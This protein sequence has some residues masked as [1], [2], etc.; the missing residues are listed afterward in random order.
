[1]HSNVM[2]TKSILIKCCG[3]PTS[4][5]TFFP[6]NGL[7]NLAS[8]LIEKGHKTIIFDFATVDMIEKMFPY[9]YR[10]EI[11]NIN[12]RFT[13]YKNKNLNIDKS[14][15][16]DAHKL[17]SEI[18]HYQENKI[19]SITQDIIKYIKLNNIDFVGIKLITG[20]G[21]KSSLIIAEELKKNIPSLPIF[22]G[23]PHVDWFMEKIYDV[24]D[25][26]D[27]LA[28]GEGEEIITML[29]DYV[30]GKKKLEEVPNII[31]RENGRIIVNPIKRIVDLNSIP[32]PVYDE[33]VYP[34]MKDNQKL[35]MVMI[36]ESRGC[37]NS[38]N[39]CIHPQKSGRKW[40]TTS[41]ERIVNI[42]EHIIEQ[43]GS[44]I[45]RFAGSNPPPYIRREIAEEI[46]KRKLKIE[47]VAFAHIRGIVK[48]EME[49]VKKSGCY[50]L[51]F[52]VE[53]GSQRIL[54]ESINKRISIEQ[55]KNSIRICK[56]SGIHI[57]VTMI[58]PAPGETEQTKQESLTLL[59]E[60]NPDSTA[61]FSPGLILNTE[62]DRNRTKY[63]F[64]IEDDKRF[65]KKA[66]FYD[67][68]PFLHHSFWEPLD[69]YKLDNKILIELIRETNEF[70]K[71]LESFGYL[72]QLLDEE[73]LVSKYSGISPRELRDKTRLYISKGD[74]ENLVLL[75]KTINK[76]IT[77]I[78]K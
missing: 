2:A 47:Y 62:W 69:E 34:A 73:I 65:F 46:L 61:I 8:C 14:I 48:E 15:L 66:M 13:E 77:E 35:K 6:D 41:P 76:N 50:V 21:F 7:S 5:R 4:L 60:L 45:F 27:V 11:E 9:P 42:I 43:T 22:A 71:K 10:K 17:N 29:A 51:A 52:G 67:S 78:H 70:S 3:Y 75:I 20:S 63:G 24:T 64:Q 36:D 23:G 40:R 37:P 44:R 74:L 31:Y 30:E 33:N 32:Y 55:I 72:T 25:V 58:I 28:Y 59:L 39:F 1:M 57:T 54:D 68:N 56:K 16:D 12:N 18:E 49:L 38:C 53:S 26:F 19:R